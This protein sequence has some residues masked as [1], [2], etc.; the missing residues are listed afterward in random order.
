MSNKGRTVI[1]WEHCTSLTGKGWKVLLLSRLIWLTKPTC[2]YV[3][4]TYYFHLDV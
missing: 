1:I 3:F 4:K 2:L